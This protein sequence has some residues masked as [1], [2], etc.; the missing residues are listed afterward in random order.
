VSEP[1]VAGTPSTRV[2]AVVLNYCREVLTEACVRSLAA[3]QPALTT[4]MV[5]NASPDG[6][7][8]RLAARFP[9][10]AFLQSGGNLGYTGGN[11]LGIAWALE[12]NAEYVFVI[13]EDAEAAPGCVAALVAALDAAPDA[14]AAV[15]TVLHAE[16]PGVVWWVGG[17]LDTMRALGMHEYFGRAIDDLPLHLRNG[18]PPR[19]VTLFSGCAVLLRASTV[20]ELGGFRDD[21]VNYLEDTEVSVRWHRAG[22]RLLHVPSAQAVH[23][24][25]F[26]P[27]EPTPYQ[28]RMRDRNRRRLA[29]EYL[30]SFE[31]L[32]FHAWFW[33][34][35]VVRGASYAL[36]GDA[37]RLRAILAGA[38]ER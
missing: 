32:R 5:D 29:R 7:G 6:S 30:G 4:V 25:A 8:A 28:I 16:P 36:R 10:I 22:C 12:R 14:G 20:R 27:L 35:R 26:P 9:D 3:Q 18:A 17:H 21:Y 24:V 19:D 38:T 15:P 23:K 2:V 13:N 34:T 31:R 1:A 11:S 33:P 37:A